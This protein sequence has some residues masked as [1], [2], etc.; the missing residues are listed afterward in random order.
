MILMS[1]NCQELGNP[2]AIR[3]LRNMVKRKGPGVLFFVETNLDAGRVKVIRVK[4]GF[5]NAFAIPSLGRSGGL[6]LLWK[7]DTDV[8]INNYSQHHIDAQMNSKQANMWHLTGFYGRPEQH[9]RKESWAFLKHLS[10]LDSLPWCCVSDFNEILSAK[11]KCGG[12][13]RFVQQ[14]LEFQAA[15]NT[16]KLVDLGY[17]RASYTWNN[18]CNTSVNVQGRLDRAMVT[19]QWLDFFPRYSVAHC[20]RSISDHLAVVVSTHLGVGTHRRKKLV[21][22]FEEQWATNPA[23]EKIIQESWQQEVSVGSPMFKLC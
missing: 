10:G 13:V 9:R 14:I 7:E 17:Q 3:A 22:R 2:E 18:N 11:E 6:A 15:V 4:L 20:P 16:C 19:T 21:R 12:R 23:C 8:V 5:D 1:W